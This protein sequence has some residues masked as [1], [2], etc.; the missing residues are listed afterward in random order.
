MSLL[1]I[2]IKKTKTNKN[3]IKQT[4]TKKN[5]K[6]KERGFF[7]S[8]V[9]SKRERTEE[10][11]I[12][13]EVENKK[14]KEENERL[15]KEIQAKDKQH[16]RELNYANKRNEEGECRGCNKFNCVCSSSED[17]D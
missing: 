10:D 15:K 11:W 3:F 4:E 16:E 6:K 9:M 14:L 12:A 13:L 2:P 1:V 17:D 5:F 7:K 8:T